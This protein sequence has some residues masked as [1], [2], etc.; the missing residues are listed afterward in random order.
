MELN[1]FLLLKVF[2]PYS[3]ATFKKQ[4]WKCFLVKDRDYF[5][6]FL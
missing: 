4:D 3:D 1:F 2:F 6:E 5:L